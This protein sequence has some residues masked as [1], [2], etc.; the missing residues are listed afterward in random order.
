MSYS[1]HGH[2]TGGPDHDPTHACTV[3]GMAYEKARADYAQA[4]Y[5]RIAARFN[6]LLAH[7]QLRTARRGLSLLR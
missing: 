4:E 2:C 6:A 7:R 3:C 5:E 1:P